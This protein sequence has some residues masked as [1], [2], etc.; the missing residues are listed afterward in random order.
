MSQRVVLWCMACM[1]AAVLAFYPLGMIG[2]EGVAGAVFVIAMV[3]AWIAA[4]A[5]FIAWLWR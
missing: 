2:W 5:G 1:G 3:T 4:G